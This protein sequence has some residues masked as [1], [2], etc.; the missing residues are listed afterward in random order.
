MLTSKFIAQGS[1]LQFAWQYLHH[2]MSTVSIRAM[3]IQ[4][5]QGYRISVAQTQRVKSTDYVLYVT[6]IHATDRMARTYND[7]GCCTWS[8]FW[9]YSRTMSSTLV[10]SRDSAFMSST[11]S[12]LSGDKQQ[13]QWMSLATPPTFF[14]YQR[15]HV[16]VSWILKNAYSR[17]GYMT[18]I[19]FSCTS[20]AGLMTSSR[21]CAVNKLLGLSR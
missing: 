5:G 16:A 4:V 17:K 11:I 8:A 18:P 7:N 12:S 21:S 20:R 1:W 9:K 14:F 15:H 6:A 2:Y 3:L 13:Q 10:L 19:R